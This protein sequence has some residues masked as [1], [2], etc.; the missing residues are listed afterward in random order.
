MDS[1]KL[2]IFTPAIILVSLVTGFV[3]AKKKY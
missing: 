2:K 3:L 1:K